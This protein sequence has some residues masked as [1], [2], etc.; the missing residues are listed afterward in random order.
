MVWIDYLIF[1]NFFSKSY[2]FLSLFFNNI[3][4][5]VWKLW[6][7]YLFHKIFLGKKLANFNFSSFI[8][9]FL[10]GFEL[11]SSKFRFKWLWIRLNWSIFILSCVNLIFIAIRI[12]AIFFNFWSVAFSV[13]YL[14]LRIL[15]LIH[16]WF[17]VF[18]LYYISIIRVQKFLI[19][20]KSKFY[21]FRVKIIF[22]FK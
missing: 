3:K 6:I 22:K 1:G 19:N 15:T 14:W 12:I 7:L 4:T 9:W 21:Y 13:Y 11:S 20:E 2:F 16:F 17:V 18:F 10:K 5:S 8:I